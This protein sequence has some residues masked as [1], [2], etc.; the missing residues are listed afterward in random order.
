MIEKSSGVR[1]CAAMVPERRPVAAPA[2][3]AKGGAAEAATLPRAAVQ[4]AP[5]RTGQGGSVDRK[6]VINYIGVFLWFSTVLIGILV[7]LNPT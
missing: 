4:R 1:P 3:R 7:V 2:P 6:W 5:E